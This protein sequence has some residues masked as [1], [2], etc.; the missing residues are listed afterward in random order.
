VGLSYLAGVY[1]PGAYKTASR[2]LAGRAS[3]YKEWDAFASLQASS[4]SPVAAGKSKLSISIGGKRTPYS[5]DSLWRAAFNQGILP[6]F[7]VIEDI[8]FNSSQTGLKLGGISV[9]KPFGG[10]VQKAAGG[11]SQARDH[12]VRMAHFVDV[13]Q[14]GNFKSFDEAVQKAGATVRKWHPDGSDLTSFERQVMRR[15]LPFYSWFRKAIPLVVESLVM[16]PGRSLVVPKAMANFAAQ[17]GIDPESLGNPFPQDQLFPD[18]LQDSTLG[19]QWRGNV[20]IPGFGQYADHYYGMNPGDPVTDLG[21]SFLGA[22]PSS[23]LL[24]SLTPAIKIPTELTTGTILGT[25]ANITDQS[26]YLD[27]QIPFVSQ[28]AN[29][30]NTSI[31]GGDPQYDVQKGR[32]EPGMDQTSIVNFLTGLGVKDYSKPNYIK[33][34]QLELRDQLRSR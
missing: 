32:S 19:P 7:N 26:D 21:N 33:A 10:R 12:W 6:D 17:M 9:T 27:A 15:L 34:A 23:S 30:T 16:H 18:W 25:G 31:T 13:L 14:K 11:L 22:S 4:K 1:N 3:A 29:I 5:D 24:G 8:A 28:A 20:G 2:I